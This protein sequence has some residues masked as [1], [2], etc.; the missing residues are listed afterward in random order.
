M[1]NVCGTAK[2]G[3]A[4]AAGESPG[5]SRVAGRTFY[6][7]RHGETEWNKTF[8]YQ[9]SSDVPLSEE[10]LRQA[11]KVAA[12]MSQVKLDR[13]IS[14]PLSRAFNTAKAIKGAADRGGGAPEIELWEDLKE[15]CFGRWEGLTVSQIKDGFGSDTFNRWRNAQLG[16]TV[17]GG[18]RHEDVAERSERAA[19]RLAA[20]EGSHIAVVGHGALFRTLLVFFLKL[21]L[22]NVFWQMRMDNCSVTVADIASSGRRS[23]VSLNDTVHLSTDVGTARR[24]PLR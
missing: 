23:L 4:D 7:I 2:R 24:L 10:G 22:S 15:I 1:T 19:E 18:E 5:L 9:G 13:L 20:I 8:R 12:R 3:P 14:S 16:I 11:E 21:P 17:P 6:F